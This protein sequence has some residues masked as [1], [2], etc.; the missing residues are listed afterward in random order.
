MRGSDVCPQAGRPGSRRWLRLGVC[1][2]SVMVIA[3]TAAAAG[4]Y[5]IASLGPAPAR[6]PA[7]V[8]DAGG[9][10][11][12]Q[13][14]AALHHLGGP[15]A[16][17]GGSRGCRSALPRDAARLRGPALQLATTGS[18]R[19]RS[20]ARSRSWSTNGR[21]VSGASTLT[22]QV[23]RLLEPRTRAHRGQRSFA[24]WCARSQ[25]ERAL[26]QG[27]D[28]L[29]L[30]QPRPL[31]RQSRRHACRLARLFRQGA[32]SADAGRSGPAGGAAAIAGAAP[33]RPLGRSG[34]PARDRVL[35]RAA[36]AGVVPADEIERASSEPVPRR[37]PADADAGAACRRRRGRRRA[38]A[39][40]S[41]GSPSKRPCS[42]ASK[43][44]RASA[45]AAS[46]PTSR[47]PCS[48]STT[49]AARC[50]R[51]SPRRTIS[52]SAAPARST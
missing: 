23:A 16:A 42:A 50:R 14:A 51:A 49:R 35:E 28:P 2:A 15:L 6:R 52:T 30:S 37:A 34:A 31:W 17:A 8:L 48:R 7:R 47:S 38:R 11:R 41:I 43:S 9:R 26:E 22:M 25:L 4:A 32:A 18:I 36:A 1:A 29:A 12:R 10:S 3:A 44:S 40:R 5:W 19:S 33:S 24:R 21:I 27:R 39:A 20:A 13:A 45:P 46:A